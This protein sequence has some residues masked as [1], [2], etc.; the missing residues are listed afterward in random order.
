MGVKSFF[1]ELKL[2]VS[3]SRLFKALVTESHEVLPKATSSI[4]SI[5]IIEGQ[6][7]AVG[8][9]CV[10]KTNFPEGGKFK[11]VKNRID[12]VDLEN[13]VCKFTTFE[14]DA[15]GEK[16]EKICYEMKIEKTEDGGCV[17]KVK[18]DY[19]TKGDIE[20][21]DEEIKVGKEQPEVLYKACE[22]YLLANPHVCT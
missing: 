2:K 14:G 20:L 3:G 6:G 9:G 18:T 17:L 8:P 13:C 5:E 16:L 19:H 7:H 1:Q 10:Y 11:Y 22:E 12:E 15:L 21:N 4:H